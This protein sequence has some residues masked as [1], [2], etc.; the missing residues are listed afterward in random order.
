MCIFCLKYCIV[1]HYLFNGT[2]LDNF[3][4]N[5]ILEI[6]DYEAFV[7]SNHQIIAFWAI[8]TGGLTGA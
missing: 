4:A 3:E 6:W 7:V 5:A 1:F 2:Q 8:Y